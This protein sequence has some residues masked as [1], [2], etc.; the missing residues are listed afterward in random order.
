MSDF[1]WKYF[2]LTSESKWK[3][4]VH[5]RAL[6]QGLK[7]TQ[8]VKVIVLRLK[9]LVNNAELDPVFGAWMAG[10]ATEFNMAYEIA[11]S[12]LDYSLQHETLHYVHD[13]TVYLFGYYNFPYEYQKYCFI[14]HGFPLNFNLTVPEHS[15]CL[16][17]KEY[18]ELYETIKVTDKNWVKEIVKTISQA[19]L[20]VDTGKFKLKPDSIIFLQR[21]N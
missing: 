2:F 19:E 4:F 18:D 3:Q 15:T 21:N 5:E 7:F 8:E 17:Y 16:I 12:V 10:G 14:V 6:L 20:P 9:E 1:E 13:L 11:G